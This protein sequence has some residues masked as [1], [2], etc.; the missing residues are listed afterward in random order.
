M[1]ERN[2]M[3]RSIDCEK[4]NLHGNQ[5]FIYEDKIQFLFS[6]K[7]EE[8]FIFKEKASMLLRYMVDEMFVPKK[9]YK[10]EILKK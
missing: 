2:D 5:I 9:Q 8:L 6:G 1:I 3:N 10:V 4:L 7:E